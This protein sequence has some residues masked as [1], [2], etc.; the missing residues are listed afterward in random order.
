MICVSH[1]GAG[2]EAE[3]WL[4]TLA[5]TVADFILHLHGLQYSRSSSLGFCRVEL[6]VC[7]TMTFLGLRQVQGHENQEDSMTG[8]LYA[9]LYLVLVAA[10]DVFA[11]CFACDDVLC[12]MS[13][14]KTFP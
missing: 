10:Y 1:A 3:T 7:E 4:G 14:S 5:C 11:F 6:R 2:Q 12:W 8:L 13:K 9:L